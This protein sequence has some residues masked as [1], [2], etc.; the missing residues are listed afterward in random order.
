MRIASPVRRVALLFFAVVFLFATRTYGQAVASVTGVVSDASGAVIAD[1]SVNLENPE[2]GSSA[3]TKTTTVGAYKFVQVLPGANYQLIFTKP[4]F[5]T[6][7]LNQVSLGAD[8]TTTRNVILEVGN[9]TQ[10]ITVTVESGP[11]LNTTD[12]SI[13]DELDL[14]SVQALPSVFRNNAA[15]LMTLAPGVVGRTNGDLSQDGSITGS[16]ADQLTITL[17]GMDVNDEEGGFGITSSI[18]LPVD[19]IQEVRTTAGSGDA[20]FGRSASGTGAFVTKSG[21]NNWH[22]SLDEYHRDTLFEANDFFNNRLGISRPPLVRNQF[23]GSLG[24]PIL[25]NK[26]FFFANY[27]GL[28]EAAGA[29]TEQIVP[30]DNVRNLSDPSNPAGGLAYINSN[31]GCTNASRQ[32]TTPSC[33][34][35]LNSQQLQNIDP[36][37][38]GANI[39]L[40]TYVDNRYPHANDL[41][42]GD[43]VNTGGFLF[44]SSAHKRQ[45]TAVARLD[46]NLSSKQRLFARGTYDHFNDDQFNLAQGVPV[47]QF[48]GDPA[49]LIGFVSHSRSWV[50]GDTWTI[51]SSLINQFNFGITTQVNAFPSRFAPT[52][53]QQLEFSVLI[54]PNLANPYGTISSQGRKVPIPEIRDDLTKT[55]GNHTLGF[56]TNLKFINVTNDLTNDLNFP[57]IGLGGFNTNLTVPG[58]NPGPLRP[59]DILQ[60]SG[61]VA[62]GLWDNLLPVT[63]GRFASIT[64]NY[65]YDKNGNL[66]PLGTDRHRKFRYNEYEFYAQDNWRVR[67]DLT[68]TY[69]LRWQVHSTPYETNGFQ[70]APTVNAGTVLADRIAA[71]ASGTSGFDA[72]PITGYKLGGPVN[73]APGYYNTDYKDFGPR[74]GIAY[75]PA[76]HDGLL[77]AIFGDRKTTVRAGAGVYYERLLGALTFELDQQTFLFD[78]QQQTSFGAGSPVTALANDPRFTSPN[79]LPAAPTTSTLPR[80]NFPNLDANGNPVGFFNGGFPAFFS[81]DRNL[82]TPRNYTVSFGVQREL[83]GNF[84]VEAD[85]F[86]RF[87]RDLLAIGDAAQTLNFKDPTSGQFLNTAFGALQKQLQQQIASGKIHFNQITPLP[88]FENQM[89]AALAANGETCESFAPPTII[90]SCTSLAAAAAPQ[91]TANGDVST[92]L[93][94][95]AARFGAVNPNVGLYAQTGADAYMGNFAASTYHGLLLSVHKRL[96]NNLQFDFHYTYSHSVDNTSDVQNTSNSFVSIGTNLVCS[97]IDLRLCRGDSNFDTRHLVSANYVYNL[98]IGRG[99]LLLK[100]APRW[101]DTLVGGWSTSGIATA[102]SGF[103]FSV[104]TGTFPIDFT[105]D[106]PAVLTGSRFGFRPGIHTDSSGQI[107]FFVDPT[108]AQS[109]FSFP[110]G[111]GT[112]NRNVVRGPGFI[113][114]DMGLNKNFKMPWKESHVLQL[115]LEAFNVFNHVNFFPPGSASLAN[116]GAFGIINGDAGP[117]TMQVA[118]RYDF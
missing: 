51:S 81:F 41:S 38:V 47:Q 31:P 26:L 109:A 29:Q 92:L 1:V 50:V 39:P 56:G 104:H 70:A 72:I 118:L 54:S 78:T 93:V 105:Q 16:R 49:P 99:Q 33:I 30:L 97:L 95:L 14:K 46:Y 90:N 43:G 5:R 59:S 45:N 64:T 108:A 71:A 84:V 36:A 24:G 21:T 18:A 61:G 89:S 80:P 115:R 19:S 28:R 35:Y 79:N 55:Y 9:V 69:G 68:I 100:G 107:Q 8:T 66:Q 22:G 62:F 117:R 96:S 112:G 17:D 37:G 32:N 67:S 10:S 57:V 13:S 58:S 74:L 87:G 102:Y 98:P 60:D 7:T 77:H 15:L 86:G 76:F 75:A 20:T 4:G 91:S 82:K 11:T 2:T 12:A 23:G 110:F 83:P 53:P 63:L 52:F 6:L 116:P 44:N 88:W 25:R 34:S 111:G 42:A 106:A 103:P 65:N 94:E 85:Y 3:A 113:N 73:N 48:P 40:L 114:F 27:I 101:L